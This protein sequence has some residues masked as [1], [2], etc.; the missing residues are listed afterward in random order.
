MTT[1]SFHSYTLAYC[2]PIYLI[3]IESQNIESHLCNPPEELFIP[4]DCYNLIIWAVTLIE[5]FSQSIR[6]VRYKNLWFK[7]EMD[8][9]ILIFVLHANKFLFEPLRQFIH[10]NSFKIWGIK[11]RN[12][13]LINLEWYD[14]CALVPTRWWPDLGTPYQTR[15]GRSNFAYISFWT[16]KM[17]NFIIST[18]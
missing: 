10:K 6:I 17:R 13:F 11:L 9:L 7:V 16:I 18:H 15:T 3:S 4:C 5:I 8:H 12:G 14:I 2:W 1:Q